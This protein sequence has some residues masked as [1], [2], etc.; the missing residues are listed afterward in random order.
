[1]MLVGERNASVFSDEGGVWASWDEGKEIIEFE[2]LAII[3][4]TPTSHL[5][6]REIEA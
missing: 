6:D 4:S 2:V 1:M 5:A 3:A